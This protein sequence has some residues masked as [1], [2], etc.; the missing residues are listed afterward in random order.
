MGSQSQT[1]KSLL[2]YRSNRGEEKVEL[3]F[4]MECDKV[5]IT[6]INVCI[7]SK[8]KGRGRS[9]PMP[10]FVNY[11]SSLHKMYYRKLNT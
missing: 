2:I 6:H 4:L 8:K 10:F 5:R 7:D 9:I 1:L 11:F 3:L